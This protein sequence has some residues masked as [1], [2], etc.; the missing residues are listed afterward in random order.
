MWQA[1]LPAVDFWLGLGVDGMRLDA[2]PYLYEREGTTCE[3]LP[4]THVFLKALRKH[5]DEKFPDRMLL[6]EANAWPEDM[7]S[8]FGTGDECHMA[9]HFPL[10]PRLYMAVH[11]ED[12]FPILDVLA[13]TPAIPDNC[14]WGLFLRNHDELTLAMVTDEERDDL[15]RAYAKDKRAK[16]FQGIRHRLAPLLG[17]DRRRIE[18]LTG[19]LVQPAGHPGAVL[20]RRVG[21]G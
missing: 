5:I 12:R 20:R 11:Q 8:Y 21:H 4:E 7:V 6:A 9:F 15:W 16:I 18:L 19:L 13:Q 3:H 14:Q 10:M 17:N 2:V 1:I